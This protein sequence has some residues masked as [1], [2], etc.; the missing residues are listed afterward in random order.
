MKSNL[1][2][3]IIFIS[4]YSS[5]RINVLGQR[6]LEKQVPPAR[7]LLSDWAKQEESYIGYLAEAL[8]D[9]GREDVATVLWRS[10]DSSRPLDIF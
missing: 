4:G 8:E 5:P 2:N 3:T 10:D 1:S 7:C 6:A 9:I